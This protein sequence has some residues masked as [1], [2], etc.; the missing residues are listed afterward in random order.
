M[1][2]MLDSWPVFSGRLAYLKLT[3]LQAK[4]EELQWTSYGDFAFAADFSPGAPA[5]AEVFKAKILVPL[6]GQEEADNEKYPLT[7]K[8]RRLYFEAYAAAA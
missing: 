1:S 6:I 4:F 5:S 8:I 2:V 7:H 3:S